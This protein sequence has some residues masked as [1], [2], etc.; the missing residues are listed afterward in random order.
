MRDMMGQLLYEGLSKQNIDLSAAFNASIEDVRAEI[1]A[2]RGARVSAISSIE[3]RLSQLEVA[4]AA[5][6]APRRGGCRIK[7][8]FLR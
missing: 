6:R 1:V 3:T 2:E 5:A 4:S 7:R 8:A